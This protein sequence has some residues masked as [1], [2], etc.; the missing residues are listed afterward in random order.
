MLDDRGEAGGE[1]IDVAEDVRL[2]QALGQRGRGRLDLAGIAGA[3]LQAAL[4]QRHLGMQVIEAPAEMREGGFGVAC[5][6]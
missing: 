4:H 5:L 3:G 6:P 2:G 1:R